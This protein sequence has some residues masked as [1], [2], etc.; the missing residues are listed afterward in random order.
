MIDR[1][2]LL[3]RTGLAALTAGFSSPQAFALENVTL[4][5]DNGERPLVRYPQIDGPTRHLA[6]IDLK[7]R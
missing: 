2:E 6:G 3:K 1:R 4:P 5:F 7:R